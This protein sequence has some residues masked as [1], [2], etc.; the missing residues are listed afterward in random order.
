MSTDFDKAAI[1]RVVSAIA[2]QLDGD[3]LLVGGAL[4]AHWLEPRRVTEDIDIIGLSDPSARLRLMELVARLGLP[5]ES[6]NSAADFFVHQI[7]GWDRELA[8]LHQGARGRILRPTPTLF[9]LLKLRRLSERDLGDCLAA[10]RLAR[11]AGLPL[12][13]ARIRAELAALGDTPDAALRLRRAA[14][15]DALEA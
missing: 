5:I 4:A 15:I 8:L 2:D 3:W 13:R 14:L 7:E 11:E 6:V 12:E 9:L 10:V 1:E